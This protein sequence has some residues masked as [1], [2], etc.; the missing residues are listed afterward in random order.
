MRSW[1][2]IGGAERQ[3]AFVAELLRV[4]RRAPGLGDGGVFVTVPH[5]FFPVEHHTA[6]PLAAWTDGAFRMACRATGKTDWTKHENLVLMS[7]R[8]WRPAALSGAQAASATRGCVSAP[9]AP[10]CI[11]RS[12]DL[13]RYV[14]DGE[15]A[16]SQASC[17]LHRF[18]ARSNMRIYS[19]G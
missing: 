8:G 6:L 13:E 7:R 1:S 15:P 4:G 3:R 18:A 2:H 19:R 5:R 14:A 11:W 12:G 16:T 9:S 10:T 17:S